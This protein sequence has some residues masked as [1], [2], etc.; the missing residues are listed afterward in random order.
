MSEAEKE[1]QQSIDMGNPPMFMGFPV[2]FSD[3]PLGAIAFGPIPK[4]GDPH[5]DAD[6]SADSP[7][8]VSGGDS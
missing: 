4:N 6:D 8:I 3:V 1:G 7:H 5:P 2:V